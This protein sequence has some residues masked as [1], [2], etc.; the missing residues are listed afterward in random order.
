MVNES[1]V[2]IWLPIY[3]VDGVKSAFETLIDSDAVA[4]GLI[5]AVVAHYRSVHLSL[6]VYV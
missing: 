1:T 2:G 6:L 3:V 4:F 5:V